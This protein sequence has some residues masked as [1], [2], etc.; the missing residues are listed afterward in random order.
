ML[1]CWLWI[2]TAIAG[3]GPWVPGSGSGS[4][5]VG[6]DAQ[7]FRMLS[8]TNGR[9][10]LGEGVHQFSLTGVLSYGVGPRA[11]VE[12][13]LP[14]HF[15][16]ANRVDTDLCADLGPGSC[17]PTHTVGTIRSHLKVLV[18]DEVSGAPLSVSVAGVVRFGAL[19]AQFRDRLTNV[20]EGTIDGGGKLSFGKS[21]ALGEGYWS[22]ALDTTAL[23]RVPNTVR[24]PLEQGERSAPGSELH[25]ET[26]TFFAPR[27][28]V[29]IGPSA[30]L[31]W[32]PQGVDFA[33]IV[34]EDIDR[35]S[36]LRV[37]QLNVGAKLIFRDTRDN[38]FV[39]GAFRTVYAMNNP[40]DQIGVSV[41]MSISRLFDP[42]AVA[43]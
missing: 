28:I 40:S 36:A 17:D 37:T 14:V 21:G 26:D 1:A 8:A 6:A 25:V 43:E 16:H 20:G 38:A 19:V 31:L 3:S 33:D 34:V 11:E 42:P 24:Y 39:V 30:N 2:S 4:L 10:L 18:A 23:Y 9:Q 7:Q 27:R 29:A 5:Y 22:T 13:V 15:A 32:R 35:F 12:V 41:G